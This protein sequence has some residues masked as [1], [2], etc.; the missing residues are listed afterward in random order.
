M[1]KN[2]IF[3]EV[4]LYLKE[5]VPY[6]NR[7]KINRIVPLITL[8]SFI[9]IISVLILF[10]AIATI[11]QPNLIDQEEFYKCFVHLTQ[12][13]SKYFFLIISFCLILFFFIL[14]NVFQFFVFKKTLHIIFGICS[15]LVTK[16]YH[17]YTHENLIESDEVNTSLKIRNITQIPYEFTSFVLFS[18]LQMLSE[19]IMIITF[20]ILLMLIDFRLIICLVIFIVPTLYLYTKTLK[21]RLKGI[22]TERDRNSKLQYKFAFESL[23]S[24]IEIKTSGKLFFFEDRFKSVTKALDKTLIDT[25]LINIIS[26]KF[27]EIIGILSLLVLVT[28]GFI[29]NVDIIELSTFLLIFALAAFRLIPSMN[30]LTLFSNNM[31]SSQHVFKYLNWD[32]TGENEKNETSL[33][34][35]DKIE[36][37]NICYHTKTNHK[38]IFDDLN[39]TINKNKA[40]GIIGESGAGKSTLINILLQ[41]TQIDKGNIFIDGVEL[42]NSNI[43]SWYKL[44]SYIPQN[45]KMIYGTV[46]ENIAFG[47]PTDQ[48]DI[49]KVEKIIEQVKLTDFINHLPKGVYSGLGANNLSISGGQAQRIG[50]ARALYADKPVL[51]FDEST[52]AIDSQTE[53]EIMDIILNLKDRTVVFITHKLDVLKKFDAIFEVKDRNIIKRSTE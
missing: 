50:I 29:F 35:E 23:E 41:L 37:I 5:H 31:K 47:L 3:I 36:F 27:T 15:D 19:I 26:P 43:N 38:L 33:S 48:I 42:S 32:L 12:N 21:K 1:F 40:I 20:S 28:F 17:S 7:K 16:R 6:E 8:V 25:N 51:V 49:K 24:L 9:E 30:K 45:T 14:K 39:F 22:S 18:Y 4:F 53:A 52:S 11:L 10:P 13:D 46:A 34:F 2:N 44:V